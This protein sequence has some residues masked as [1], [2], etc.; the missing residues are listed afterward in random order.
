VTPAALAELVRSVAHDVLT[1]RGLDPAVLPATVTVERPRDPEHG[2]YAT[3]LAL[4][5]AKKAAV[6]PREFA[7][8]VQPRSPA[9]AFSTCG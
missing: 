9:P 1:G 5:A 2:D 7:A 3:N 8:C 4:Q 6:A